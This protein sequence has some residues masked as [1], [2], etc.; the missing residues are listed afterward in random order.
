M[1]NFVSLAESLHHRDV[2]IAH[3][4]QA[5]IRNDN[6]RVTHVAQSFDPLKSLL[7]PA[8]PFEGKRTGH[9]TDGQ[10]TL[11]LRNARDHR[12][13]TRSGSTTFTCGNEDHIRTLQGGFNLVT[14][15][16]SRLPTYLRVG[17]SPQATG[18]FAA[19]VKLDVRVSEHKRLRV[20]VHGDE[21][22]SLEA[23]FNHAIDSVDAA[24]ANANHFDD[25]EVVIRCRHGC[26]ARLSLHDLSLSN[27]TVCAKTTGCCH[28]YCRGATARSK[29]F[30]FLRFYN[31]CEQT[32]HVVTNPFGV[33]QV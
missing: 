3:L 8:R 12:G 16:L 18:R 10:R 27:C 1:E 23:I 5:V 22:D 4:K 13:G 32:K 7:R 9:N 30:Y 17:A 14:M 15:I 24:A 20:G 19:D 33:S 21:L 26:R 25:G 29:E 11:F 28:L 6:Q 2:L 31:A